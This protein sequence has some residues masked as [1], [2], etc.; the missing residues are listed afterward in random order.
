MLKRKKSEKHSLASYPPVKHRKHNNLR[1][2]NIRERPVNFLNGTKR[3]F[4][5]APT[6]N[7][8]NWAS[9]AKVFVLKKSKI[10]C[11]SIL[12]K[13]SCL[14]LEIYIYKRTQL[15]LSMHCKFVVSIADLYMQGS[16]YKVHTY[17]ATFIPLECW[18]Q[19]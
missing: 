1:V 16:S 4:T 2:T 12:H 14:P 6:K 3:V 8:A 9:F 7:F 17:V 5:L 15:P 10:P 18:N 13:W 11:T 19:G